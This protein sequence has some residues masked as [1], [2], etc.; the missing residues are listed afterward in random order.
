[1]DVIDDRVKT[2][3]NLKP[4]TLRTDLHTSRI[5]M[6]I[7]NEPYRYSTTSDFDHDKNPSK[8]SVSNS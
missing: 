3:A 6:N 7:K 4:N 5:V 2:S 8:S 1:M